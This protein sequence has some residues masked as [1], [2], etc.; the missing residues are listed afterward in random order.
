M[1]NSGGGGS[2]ALT[3][4]SSRG[5]DFIKTS[6]CH[7]GGNLQLHLSNDADCRLVAQGTLIEMG[8]RGG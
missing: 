5:M 6:C 7:L 1:L 8:A 4:N 2:G 3:A